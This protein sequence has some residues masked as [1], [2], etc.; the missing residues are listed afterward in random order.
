MGGGGALPAR[1]RSAVPS[2]PFQLCVCAPRPTKMDAS[3]LAAAALAVAMEN[4]RSAA[5][6]ELMLDRER[7]AMV[8]EDRGSFLIERQTICSL[9]DVKRCPHV[10]STHREANL[11]HPTYERQ[12]RRVGVARF[13]HSSVTLRGGY[14]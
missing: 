10:H 13:L 9:R 12:W 7:A 5:V 14:L 6:R 4:A 1:P 3:S 11:A 2:Q 8:A